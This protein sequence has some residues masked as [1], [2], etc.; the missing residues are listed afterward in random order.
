M[1]NKLSIYEQILADPKGMIARQNSIVVPDNLI[2]YGLALSL[3]EREKFPNFLQEDSYIVM[4][5]EIEHKRIHHFDTDYQDLLQNRKKREAE[6]LRLQA[7]EALHNALI[8]KELYS[9]LYDY[10]M[11]ETPLDSKWWRTTKA[12]KIDALSG[13]W[14]GSVTK[15]LVML[16]REPFIIWVNNNLKT[17]TQTLNKETECERWLTGLMEND[18]PQLKAKKN[19]Y[20]EEAKQLFSGMGVRQFGRSWASAMK[21]TNNQT[22]GKPGPKKIK[23][24]DRDTK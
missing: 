11:N 15:G 20:Y 7:K 8:Q 24:L 4:R 2:P 19:D 5:N 10:D 17:P 22:W 14:E 13:L 1:R 3:L 18:Q 9:F 21:K 16:E 23:T 6:E 12:F